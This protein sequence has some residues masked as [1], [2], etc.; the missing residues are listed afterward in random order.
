MPKLIDDRYRPVASLVLG[1]DMTE[2]RF[3]ESR[4]C[5]DMT[6]DD[7]FKLHP[8][9]RNVTIVDFA[10]LEE[11]I[12]VHTI[13]YHL[14]NVP[15]NFIRYIIQICI[16]IRIELHCSIK[17]DV[18]SGTIGIVPWKTPSLIRLL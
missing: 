5:T 8:P 10:D 6:A 16:H 13:W 14:H 4:E 15:S 11:V 2:S 3:S 1:N 17:D 7:E 9:W 18:I 12:L